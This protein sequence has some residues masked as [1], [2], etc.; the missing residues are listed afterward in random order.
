MDTLSSGIVYRFFF[1]FF[2]L[3]LFREFVR[4]GAEVGKEKGM[5]E[6]GDATPRCLPQAQ[7]CNTI[8]HAR[9]LLISREGI[10]NVICFFFFCKVVSEINIYRMFRE[11]L[12][13][14]FGRKFFDIRKLI[15]FQVQKSTCDQRKKIRWL[16][17]KDA[18]IPGQSSYNRN[19]Q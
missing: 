4:E 14:L 10:V 19:I 3:S 2:F 13:S 16:K 12:A 17:A 9:K 8:Q 11:Y 7:R 18:I 5:R 15:I 1:L 6:G